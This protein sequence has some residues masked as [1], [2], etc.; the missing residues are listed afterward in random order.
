MLSCVLLL[1]LVVAL[2]GTPGRPAAAAAYR[3]IDL[4]PLPG[5]AESRAFGLNAAGQVVGWSTTSTGSQHA[6]RWNADGSVTDLGTL[7]G[8]TSSADDINDAGQVVGGAQTAAM[9]SH[10]VVWG[11]GG[12]IT[13]LGTFGGTYSGANDINDTGQVVGYAY[14]RNEYPLAFR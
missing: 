8:A 14:H 2:V 4:G 7:G 3:L 6:V 12:A 10:A 5:G 13:D 9:D 11:P 1:T